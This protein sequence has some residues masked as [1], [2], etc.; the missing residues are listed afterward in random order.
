MFMLIIDLMFSNS[1]I[2]FIS[3]ISIIPASIF[4][5]IVKVGSILV[6]FGVNKNYSLLDKIIGLDY[7]GKLR[8][9]FLS[10]YLIGLA[11]KI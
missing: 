7:N 4:I 1:V 3:M 10:L 11:L 2:G 6:Y 5:V 9:G 8:R